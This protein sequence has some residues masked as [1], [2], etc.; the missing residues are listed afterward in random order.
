MIPR[1]FFVKGPRPAAEEANSVTCA[2][3]N[4][5]LR[6]HGLSLLAQSQFSP[7]A[8]QGG[9][10]SPKDYKIW[11]PLDFLSFLSFRIHG[12]RKRPMPP[13]GPS[14]VP[15]VPLP[16]DSDSE[17]DPKKATEGPEKIWVYPSQTPRSN[18]A[19][20][21]LPQRF[22]LGTRLVSAKGEVCDHHPNVVQLRV[23]PTWLDRL[24]SLSR[25]LPTL[26]RRV[27]ES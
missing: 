16:L 14:C 7:I 22:Q 2:D 3:T 15:Q 25:F 10:A 18:R 27:V 17:P 4:T 12:E 23:L 21:S 9:T 6:F 8:M 26:L 19:F 5:C 11:S 1:R 20:Y 13:P 24:F